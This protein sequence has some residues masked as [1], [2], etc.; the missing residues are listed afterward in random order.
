MGSLQD[1]M[2][3]QGHDVRGIEVKFNED[4]RYCPVCAADW[5]G[6][7]IPEEHRHLYASPDGYF[8]RLIGI[9][10]PYDDPKHRD[11]VSLWA[12]PDCATQ[13]DRFT[14]ERV[15]A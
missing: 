4:S 11:G 5:R 7:P 10:L 1:R 2:E 9:E 15:E 6:K 8:S 3:D 12:C 13:W 14:G